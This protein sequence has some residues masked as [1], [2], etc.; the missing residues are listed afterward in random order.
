[1][2]KLADRSIKPLQFVLQ[3]YRK[4]CALCF[5]GFARFIP[6]A[7]SEICWIGKSLAAIKSEALEQRLSV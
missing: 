6:T 2:P 5:V 4:I 7:L 1:M 3:H